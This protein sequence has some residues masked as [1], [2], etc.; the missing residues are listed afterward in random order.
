[1]EGLAENVKRVLEGFI[2]AL[3]DAFGSDLVSVV[4]YGSAAE[5]KMRAASDVNVI[6]VFTH[7]SRASA[8]RIREPL[9]LAATAVRMRAMFLL[10]EEIGPASEA[11]AQK[12]ADI[13]H[14]RKI[15]HGTD[16]FDGLKISRFAEIYRLKQVLLN[17]TLRL[18]ESY[19]SHGGNDEEV[20]AL[21]ADA[22]GPLR[23]SAA[24][25]LEL[26][27]AEPRSPKESFE[28]LLA[29]MDPPL[30][31]GLASAV[32]E[33]RE[34]RPLPSGTAAA[35]L[36]DIIELSSRMRLRAERLT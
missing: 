34:L 5:G 25:L 20:T 30:S 3:K 36:L 26:E 22:S 27:G 8:E 23:T 7:F 17:L 1:M 29:G 10:V 13:L 11:F 16:P 19:I 24:I 21:I 15:L 9:N 12:F 28:A 32:S 14:R 4:L 18:R 35:Y 6:V 2:Q 31:P 33:A